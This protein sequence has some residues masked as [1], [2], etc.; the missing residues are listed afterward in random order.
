MKANE[1]RIGNYVIEDYMSYNGIKQKEVE[2]SFKNLVSHDSLKPIPLTEEWLV[3][4]GF[5]VENKK[6]NNNDFNVYRKG[7]FT[8]NTNHG[9]WFSHNILKLQPQ[10]V[11]QLQN[12]YFALIGTEL[13]LNK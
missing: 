6:G 3:K 11:H 4:F 10:F 12:L 2:V 1:L 9:W 8:F 5:D 7:E 13:T